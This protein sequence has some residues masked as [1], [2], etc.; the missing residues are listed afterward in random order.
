MRGVRGKAGRAL[1]LFGGGL[2]LGLRSLPLDQV[3][4]GNDGQLLERLRQSPGKKPA[5]PKTAKQKEDSSAKNLPAQ[6]CLARKQLIERVDANF[7]SG[8]VGGILIEALEEERVRRAVD[9]NAQTLF[10]AFRLCEVAGHFPPDLF[11]GRL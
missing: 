4:L 2:E 11:F 10:F 6:P 3:F 5:D 9:F 7:V 1:Q 8:R